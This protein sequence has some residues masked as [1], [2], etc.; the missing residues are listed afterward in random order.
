MSVLER[1]CA[2]PGCPQCTAEQILATSPAMIEA[3]IEEGLKH[4]PRIRMVGMP[5]GEELARI[6][7][8]GRREAR[9]FARLA[10]MEPHECGKEAGAR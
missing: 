2:E 1:F 8:S 6:K 5:A 7:R 3:G 9:L 4:D 10:L